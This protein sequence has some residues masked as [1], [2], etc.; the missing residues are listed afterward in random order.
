MLHNFKKKQKNNVFEMW[1]TD[2]AENHVG[3]IK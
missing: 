2:T 1:L 3:I